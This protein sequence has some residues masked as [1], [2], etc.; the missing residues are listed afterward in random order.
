MNLSIKYQAQVLQMLHD[1][2]GHHGMERTIDLCREHFYWNT[3]YKDIPEYIK[4]CPQWQ[5][6]K[7]H[8][9]GPKTKTGFIIANGPL[10][11]LCV[12]FTNVS[13]RIW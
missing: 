8:Y 5:V 1:G 11:L 3:M 9:V 7:G 4:I 13:I 6:A 10:D 12:D 2:Q